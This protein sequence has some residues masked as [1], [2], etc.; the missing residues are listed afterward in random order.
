MCS[1]AQLYKSTPS[2]TVCS[3]PHSVRKNRLDAQSILRSGKWLAGTVTGLREQRPNALHFPRQPLLA[4]PSGRGLN[5]AYPVLH[6]PATYDEVT[7]RCQVGLRLQLP[8]LEVPAVQAA[9]L[10]SG[11]SRL[12]RG[13][14]RSLRLMRVS[15]RYGCRSH[16]VLRCLLRMARRVP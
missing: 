13:D 8:K 9:F 16:A 5:R 1:A 10:A 3:P 14:I 2:R 11:P 4:S 12:L 6:P 7:G 15:C